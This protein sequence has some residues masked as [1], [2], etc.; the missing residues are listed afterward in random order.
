MYGFQQKYRA[1]I[2]IAV[3]FRTLNTACA[4]SAFSTDLEIETQQRGQYRKAMPHLSVVSS[5]IDQEWFL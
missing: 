1:E 5:G 3:H 4:T 2:L